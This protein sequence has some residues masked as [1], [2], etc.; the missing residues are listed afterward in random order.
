M[1]LMFLLLALEVNPESASL[2]GLDWWF[3]GLLEGLPIYPLQEPVTRSNPN[4]KPPI[5][6]C[7]T[8]AAFR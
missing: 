4:P 7:L 8:K 5:G 3:G 6:G 1:G 2:Q